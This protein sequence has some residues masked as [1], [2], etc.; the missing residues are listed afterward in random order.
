MKHCLPPD[1]LGEQV[2]S[3]ITLLNFRHHASTPQKTI[4]QISKAELFFV[5]TK[6]ATSFL[7]TSGASAVAV[8]GAGRETVFVLTL[9]IVANVAITPTP[10]ARASAEG[11]R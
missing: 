10:C 7:S 1:D 3:F 2:P 4:H 11:N 5:L 6:V 9:P 8:V